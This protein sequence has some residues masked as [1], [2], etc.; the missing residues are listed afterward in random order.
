MFT[1]LFLVK[2]LYVTFTL[3]IF[4]HL[5][6]NSFKNSNYKIIF[7]FPLKIQNLMLRELKNNNKINHQIK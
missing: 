6:Q 7:F 4:K 3:E 5:L 2:N 1:F